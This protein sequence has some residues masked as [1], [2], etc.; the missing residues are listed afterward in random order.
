MAAQNRPQELRV[1]EEHQLVRDNQDA[2]EKPEETPHCEGAPASSEGNDE[3]FVDGG[4]AVECSVAADSFDAKQVLAI[5]FDIIRKRE[6]IGHNLHFLADAPHLLENLHG[7]LVRQQ[8]VVLD[9]ET[10]VNNKLP[11]NED[12]LENLFR[13]TRAKSPVPIA[14]EF[15][16]T[17]RLIVLAQF[18]K[19]NDDELSECLELINEHERR[20]AEERNEKLIRKA[21]ERDL[22]R[23]RLEIELLKARGS[24]EALEGSERPRGLRND[25]HHPA[26]CY[27]LGPLR[28]PTRLVTGLS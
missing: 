28:P 2:P 8:K 10:L 18:F 26:P 23:K 16:Y 12:A 27:L 20:K 25:D 3:S 19:P 7:H 5:L 17:L 14:R 24:S 9:D 11:T 1:F 13:A 22:E 21:E 15:K 4:T 6:A